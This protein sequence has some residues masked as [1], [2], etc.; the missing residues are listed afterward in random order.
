MAKQEGSSFWPRMILTSLILIWAAVVVGQL[1]G[2]RAIEKYLADDKGITT[3][4]V[5]APTPR[6]WVHSA[7]NLQAEIDGTNLDEANGKAVV[8]EPVNGEGSGIVIN[9]A[10]V[11]NRSNGSGGADQGA[12]T[13]TPEEEPAVTG[14]AGG[15]GVAVNGAKV[16]DGAGGAEGGNGAVNHTAEPVNTVTGAPADDNAGRVLLFGAF[17]LRETV[18]SLVEQLQREGVAYEIKEVPVENGTVYRV[19]SVPYSSAKEASEKLEA[20]KGAGIEA[21]ID[22]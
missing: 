20:L 16:V 18:D 10:G 22:E 12:L 21:Y 5:G 11:L 15:G 6:P 8:A 2:Q 9:A 14:G 17:H 3:S 7:A 4:G 19:T 13:V 1:L